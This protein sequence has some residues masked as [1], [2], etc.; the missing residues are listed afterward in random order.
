M[1]RRYDPE[2]PSCKPDDRMHLPYRHWS[3]PTSAM[4]SRRRWLEGCGLARTLGTHRAQPTRLTTSCHAEHKCSSVRHSQS[5][6]RRRS[7][8]R[9]TDGNQH[10][11]VRHLDFVAT[12]L[13]A[14]RAQQAQA[15]AGEGQANSHRTSAPLSSY[16]SQ[17]LLTQ[18]SGSASANNQDIRGEIPPSA[19]RS[20]G[21]ALQV[22]N[23]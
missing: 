22:C 13:S 5:N 7:G 1:C 8:G 20:R 10:R 4:L 3:I 9:L 23:I 19:I 18:L 15:P 11:C 17:S 14:A 2:F 6:S 12:W 16:N 21:I